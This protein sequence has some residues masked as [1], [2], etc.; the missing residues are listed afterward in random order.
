MISQSHSGQN[1]EITKKYD[2][3]IKKYSYASNGYYLL[4]IDS[5]INWKELTDLISK[6]LKESKALKFE[7]PI[8]F[9]LIKSLV[10]AKIFNFPD[11]QIPSEIANNKIYMEFLQIDKEE[12]IPTI[13]MIS[14]FHQT[15][16]ENSLYDIIMGKFYKQLLEQNFEITH[17][18]DFNSNTNENEL[19]KP[20]EED[21]NINIDDKLY[22]QMY[23]LFFKTLD[24]TTT[25]DF[26]SDKEIRSNQMMKKLKYVDDIINELKK[27]LD[28]VDKISEMTNSKETEN[29]IN[30]K[31]EI[32]IDEPIELYP[33][34]K[35]EGIFNDENLTEDYEIGY[36]FHQLGLKMGF[37]NVKLDNNNESSR[38]STAEFFPNT[39][40]TSVK[41]RSRWIAGICL[42]N[43]K[44]HKWKGNLTMK[45]FLFRDRKPLFSLLG[46]FLSNVI[47]FYLVY[48]IITNLLF[49]GNAVFLVSHSPVL[50]YIMA[51]NVIFMVSRASHRFVFTYNWYGFKY[52]FYSFFRL[53]L[54]TAINFFAV[55]RS[56]SVY[57]KTKKKVVWDSTSH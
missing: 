42:Q 26:L 33:K 21:S 38:I 2:N 37:F 20:T 41:Q 43:W 25:D 36:R 47:F 52:A 3:I 13:K 7:K 50:W 46:A 1:T 34:F 12:K 49:G 39:F 45:Y 32:K 5:S 8:I 14:S 23:D 11:H 29:K 16:I 24:V 30:E 44:A 54:D 40:W 53:I 4:R 22:V 48:V 18:L 15:L 56:M 10:L 57:R 55:L 28:K 19:N 35:K 27:R 17:S 51:A 6:N 9:I 31:K